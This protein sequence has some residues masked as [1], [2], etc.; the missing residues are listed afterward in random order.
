[1]PTDRQNA[2]YKSF[3][4]QNLFDFSII[5]QQSNDMLQIYFFQIL[6]LREN[7]IALQCHKKREPNQTAP[8]F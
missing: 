2:Y 1:V 5:N 7:N 3:R 8:F 4:L 6:R